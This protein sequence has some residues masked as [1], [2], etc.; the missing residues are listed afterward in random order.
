MKEVQKTFI[1]GTQGSSSLNR[2]TQSTASSR[3][4]ER[5]TSRE[6][7]KPDD[8]GVTSLEISKTESRTSRSTVRSSYPPVSNSN[9]TSRSNS[10]EPIRTLNNNAETRVFLQP[11]RT[12]TSQLIESTSECDAKIA[13]PDV[14]GWDHVNKGAG[15]KEQ[16]NHPMNRRSGMSERFESTEHPLDPR[17]NEMGHHR[18]EKQG[19]YTM[20]IEP[21]KS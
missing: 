19:R 12:G 16:T 4:R 9:R 13:Q 5:S 10:R 17:M 21:K 7:I 6:R 15:P 1:K 18:K 11:E 8:T 2:L 20:M 14:T 3:S